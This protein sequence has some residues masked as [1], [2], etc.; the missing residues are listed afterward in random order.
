MDKYI[1]REKIIKIIREFFYK[2]DFH[3]VIPP[4]L[5]SAVPNEPNLHPFI[6]THEHS[7]IKKTFYLSMS[8]E[9]GIKKMLSQ[10]MGNCFAIAKSFRNYERTGSLHM[11]EFLMLEWYRKG[12]I[13]TEI[14]SDL[15]KLFQLINQKMGN[16]VAMKEGPFPRLSL[17]TLFKEK[18]GVDLTELIG[19]DQLMRETAQKKGYTVAGGTSWEELYNQ[20]FV[21]E[22]ESGF[23]LKPFF[24]TDFPARISPLCKTQQS[25]PLLAERFELYVHKIELANG[26]TE[27]T[28]TAAIRKSFEEESKKTNL[29]LDS[30]FISSLEGMKKSSYAGVGVGIDRLS[31]L[32]TNENIFV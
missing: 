8:P 3:E 2:Q 32:F 11:H 17:I 31:H 16:K 21:N 22:I 1:V 27:N 20:L 5:N 6:T 25:N 10:G 19:S 23:S 4:L 24:L 9:R 30:E 18:V 14:M 12:A 26:N 7:G 15:E 13:Y 28:D 29:P